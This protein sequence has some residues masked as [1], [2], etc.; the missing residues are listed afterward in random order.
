MEEKRL[1]IEVD[2]EIIDKIIKKNKVTKRTVQSALQYITN[3]PS[4]R[5]FRA[6]ALNNGGKLY[7]V[8]KREIEN[9]YLE[10]INL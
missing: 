2:D 8:I 4:A 7:E 9:P 10:V 6:Y 5:M 3:S 1:V